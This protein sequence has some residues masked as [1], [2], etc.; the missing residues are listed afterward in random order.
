VEQHLS[1]M[2]LEQLDHLV[3]CQRCRIRAMTFAMVLDLIEAA[4]GLQ[5]VPADRRQ[6]S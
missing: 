3:R 6:A 1:L 4:Y 2:F 5:A